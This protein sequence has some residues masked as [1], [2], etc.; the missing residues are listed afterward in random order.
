MT[1]NVIKWTQFDH[2][3]RP[4]VHMSQT[5]DQL[6]WFLLIMIGVTWL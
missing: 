3:I 1:R 2:K 5:A 4:I 6:L